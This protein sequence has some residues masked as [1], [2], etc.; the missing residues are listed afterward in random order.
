MYYLKTCLLFCCMFFMISSFAQGKYG[1][2]K[3][4]AFAKELVPG[5]RP[6]NTGGETVQIMPDTVF[7]VYL[8]TRGP[9]AKWDTAWYNS[10]M[11]L[12]SSNQIEENIFVAGFQKNNGQKIVI[13]RQAKNQLWVLELNPYPGNSKPPRILKKGEILLSGKFGTKKVTQSVRSFRLL[14]SLSTV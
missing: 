10:K 3:I 8:E 1:I 14:S 11:Y 9:I 5:N 13:T 6:A 4:Q 12:I 2:R 7:M